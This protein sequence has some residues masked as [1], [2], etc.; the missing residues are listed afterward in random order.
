MIAISLG[1]FFSYTDPTYK[2]VKEL[3]TQVAS[4]D[5]ALD[6]SKKLEE[7]K[8]TLNQQY[9]TFSED[10][11]ER[12]RKLLPDNV[13]NIRLILEI[14][15]VAVRYGMTIKNVEFDV[16][17]R[18]TT[19]KEVQESSQDL[20]TAQKEYGIFD[21]SFSTQ[22]TYP[23][24]VAFLADIEKSLRIVDINQIDF[25]SP[26]NNPV[27]GFAQPKDIYKYEISLRTYWLKN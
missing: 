8:N 13:D 4:Y 2:D 18:D 22:G 6:N 11:L 16:A 27:Q 21:L 9:N 12:L 3:R 15:S 5:E 17:K 19:G 1:I 20:K 7:A 24:F 23:N 26:D 10:E 25:T 14:E